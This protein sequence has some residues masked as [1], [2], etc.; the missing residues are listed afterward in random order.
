MY[1]Y[2]C[3]RYT[4]HHFVHCRLP[5]KCL[6]ITYHNGGTVIAILAQGQV[7]MYNRVDSERL[8]QPGQTKTQIVVL[9]NTEQHK[10]SYTLRP[11]GVPQTV[12]QS[13]CALLYLIRIQRQNELSRFAA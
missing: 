7:H 4:L 12:A 6:P 8:N 13:H 5:F 9:Q 3:E 10:L 1:R 11:C 2:L